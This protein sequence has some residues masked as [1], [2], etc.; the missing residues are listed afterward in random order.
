MQN[1]KCI[2]TN[3]FFLTTINCNFIYNA[4]LWNIHFLYTLWI[5]FLPACACWCQEVFEKTWCY[6][7][8]NFYLFCI[9][10]LWSLVVGENEWILFEFGKPKFNFFFLE[11]ILHFTVYYVAKIP[12]A[13][14]SCL[15]IGKWFISIVILWK[16][17][18]KKKLVRYVF[19]RLLHHFRIRSWSLQIC[20]WIFYQLS[21]TT[22]VKTEIPY[23]PY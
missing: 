3:L 14:S 1:T 6:N 8:F 13:L 23:R 18:T 10:D 16:E 11:N 2:L 17:K 4:E 12:C 15:I 22:N 19:D 21:Q 9:V 20:F 5:F 7:W